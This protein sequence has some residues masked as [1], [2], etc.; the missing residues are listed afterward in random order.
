MTRS[1]RAGGLDLLCLTVVVGLVCLARDV[2]S[3]AEKPGQI[4]GVWTLVEQKNGDAQ[5]FQKLP[6]GSEQ[7]KFVTG[8]RFVWVLVREG[9]IVG[10]AG[11]KYTVDKDKYIENI[12]YAHGEGQTSLVGKAFEFTWKFDG[13]TWHHVGVIKVDGQDLKIDEKWQRCK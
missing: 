1:F 5:E 3:Q 12:E 11:G 10:A 2:R 9:R 8:G 6:E 13:N 7:I 4:E